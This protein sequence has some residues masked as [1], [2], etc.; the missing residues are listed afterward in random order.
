MA[1][2]FDA[3]VENL[4]RWGESSDKVY[5]AL[6]IGSQARKDYYAD[7]YSDLDIVMIVDE[8]DYFLSSDYWLSNI[9]SFYISFIENTIAGEKE[10]RILF[11]DALDVDFVILSKNSV[12]KLYGEAAVILSRGYHILLDKIG[13]EHNIQS[14]DIIQPTNNFLSENDFSNIVNDFWYH[15]VW[16]AKKIKRGEMWTAKMCMDSY[17]K[18]KLLSI[19]ENHAHAI[20]GEEYD[21][22]HNGRF[23]EEWAEHWIIDKLT[24]CFSHY[25]KEDMR[26]ALITTMELFRSVAIEA[27]ER[28]DFQYPVMADEYAAAWVLKEL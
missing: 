1:N 13:L 15:S 24:Q 6:V 22:W 2:K 18:W 19:I 16:T 21:T 23:I 14:A 3:I 4:I 12:N 17:M 27:A 8:P 26:A 7:D 5:A 28:L 11:D 9:G 20:H 25:N 10:R